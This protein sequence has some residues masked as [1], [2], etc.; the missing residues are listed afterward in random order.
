ME[1]RLARPRSRDAVGPENGASAGRAA[2]PT[3]PARA[4]GNW[5]RF[6]RLGFPAGLRGLGMRAR[7]TSKPSAGR[8]A[9]PRVESA[10]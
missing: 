1:C 3:E 9:K 7:V 10:C 5:V 8:R 4:A 6:K 2:P